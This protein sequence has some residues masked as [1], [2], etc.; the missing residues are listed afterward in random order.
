MNVE[1]GP[2]SGTLKLPDDIETK[3]IVLIISGSGPID[4]DGNIQ[5]G[6]GKNNSLKLIAESLAPLGIASLRYD[7]RLV[8]L[9]TSKTFTEH[10]IRFDHYVAD[11]ENWLNFLAEKFEKPLFV[12]GHSEGSLIGIV[13]ASRTPVSGLVS[14]AGTART[15]SEILLEQLRDRLSSPQFQEAERVISS[16]N[17]GITTEAPPELSAIFRP[18]VQPYLISWFRYAPITAISELNVSI[19][20]IHGTTDLQVPIEDAKMLHSSAPNSRLDIINGMNH[21]L[22]TVSGDLQT[23][24]PSYSD[25]SLRLPLELAPSI[26][27][28]I[29]QVLLEER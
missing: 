1:L 23:Q 4:R 11:A 24:L 27:E 6:A 21:V 18:S 20:I 3:A 26:D 14:I 15:A 25:P 7:K 12:I 29:T 2:I 22:K 28:F 9:S 5:G 10:D 16:L 8:G 17:K 19:Q 13:A